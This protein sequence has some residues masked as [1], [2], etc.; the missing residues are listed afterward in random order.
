MRSI[1]LLGAVAVLAIVFYAFNVYGSG[2]GEE[3]VPETVWKCSL[4]FMEIDCACIGNAISLK[5]SCSGTQYIPKHLLLLHLCLRVPEPPNLGLSCNSIRG[6]PE[7]LKFSGRRV[8][9]DTRASLIFRTPEPN[10]GVIPVLVTGIHFAAW[11]DVAD[12]SARVETHLD[13]RHGTRVRHDRSR[14]RVPG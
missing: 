11:A 14:Q 6:R 12:V 13:E 9:S 8:T 1:I 2:T 3:I 7:L 5:I 10:N 4:V